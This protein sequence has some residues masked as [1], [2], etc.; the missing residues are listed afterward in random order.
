M[1]APAALALAMLFGSLSAHAQSIYGLTLRPTDAAPE[2]APRGSADIVSANGTYEVSVNLSAASGVLKLDAFRGASAFVVWAV[3]MDGRS[4]R[5]G[6]L[7]EQL[8]LDAAR[9]EHLIARLYITA[10]P[11]AGASNPTGARLYEVTLRNVPEAEGVV[12]SAQEAAP[13]TEA[14]TA[15]PAPAGPTPTT[16]ARNDTPKVLPTTGTGLGDLLVL[17]AAGLALVAA[18]LRLRAVRL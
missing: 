14:A 9:V 12:A 17:A 10:E 7:D 3:D 2:G 4:G 13:P 15:E 8:R 1:I 5:V 18:G 6:A 11:A 16:A